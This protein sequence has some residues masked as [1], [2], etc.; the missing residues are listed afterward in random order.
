MF[1]NR[2]NALRSL[3]ASG[4]VVVGASAHAALPEGVS[5]AITTYQTDALAAI[6]L[7]MAAGVAI[8][9]LNKLASKL[10]WK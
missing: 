7:V 5:D 9:G 1:K 4:A 3:V 10:G 6:G 2:V 8:W